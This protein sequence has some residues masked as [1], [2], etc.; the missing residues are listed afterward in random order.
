MYLL[1]LPLELIHV[2]SSHLSL[3]DILALARVSK[4]MY[5][6]LI[7]TLHRLARDHRTIRRGV[8]TAGLQ[9]ITFWFDK[10]CGSSVIEWAIAHG[11]TSTFSQLILDSELDLLQA[12]TYGVTLMH[13]LSGQG[14]VTYME[15]LIQNMNRLGADPF[16][17]DL[18]LLTPLHYA[19]GRGMNLAVC[20]LLRYGSDVSAKDHHG[21]TPLHLAALTGSH[22]VF[23]QLIEA[24][25]D[26][27]SESR[28]N[29][30][31]IDQAS[32]SHHSIAVDELSRLGSLP[33]TWQQKSNALNEFVRLSPCP[34]E[35]Y[36]YH[37]D[38]S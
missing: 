20:I 27:N 31:P 33:P 17:V 16:Q 18:S 29:W 11:R 15:P 30:R 28:F 22:Q 34:L 37:M 38:F 36:A 3:P 35:C 21:N 14:L 10:S 1:T 8:S 23:Q 9:D 19:A 25:A 13:R 32:I 4:L 2:I 7:G 12:D 6:Q 26:V 24:G 5:T